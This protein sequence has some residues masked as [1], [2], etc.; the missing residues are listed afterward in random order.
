[1]AW[2]TPF[3]TWSNEKMTYSDMNRIAG[4]VNFLYPG[5][6]LKDNYTQNDYLLVSEY[7]ALT[8][9][10][11]AL[12]ATSGLNGTVP[13]WNNTPEVLNSLETLIQD[14]YDRIALNAA[15]NV[16]AAYSGDDLYT[17]AV[18]SYPNAEQYT[19]GVF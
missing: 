3:T 4:N 14:L 18:G 19:R 10:L 2:V 9:A 5:A 1:M 12:I 17:A 11:N 8:N 6:S 15:Q 16:A 13:A 7:A